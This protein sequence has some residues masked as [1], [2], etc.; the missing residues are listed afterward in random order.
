MASPSKNLNLHGSAPDTSATALL[1]I[2]VIN[3]LE[4]EGAEK[5]VKPALA[6][7]RGLVE[8]KRR[9]ARAS[10]PA[11]YVNDNFGRW[12]EDQRAIIARALEPGTRGRPVAELLKPAPDDYFVVKP[13]HS[14]FFATP[15][16]T[17]L[18]YLRVRTLILTGIGTELCVLFT[19]NDAYMRDYRLVVPSDCVTAIDSEE[20]T[21]ALRRMVD[22]LQA[23]VRASAD[24]R[25][26][27]P[28]D[29][30][31]RASSSIWPR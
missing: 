16:D 14:G 25:L 3:A 15:L 7:A 11:I 5:L 12:R 8:L 19:A 9:C 2:D 13:K 24:V 29:S 31:L 30:V 4:F 27:Q 28:S 18:T 23:D 26:K 17:L 21:H 10:I 6:M 1:L 20:G 22:A